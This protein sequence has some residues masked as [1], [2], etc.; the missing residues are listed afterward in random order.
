MVMF[1]EVVCIAVTESVRTLNPVGMETG[2]KPL[3]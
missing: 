1:D 3:D 2:A